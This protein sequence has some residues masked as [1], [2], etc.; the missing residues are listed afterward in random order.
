M[1]SFFEFT[2]NGIKFS[3]F[4]DIREELRNAWRATWGEAIDLSPTSPDGHHVDLEAKT[5]TFIT[6]ALQVVST[7]FNRKQAT[8]Q[9]LDYLAFLLHLSRGEGESDEALRLRMDEAETESLATSDGMITYLRDKIDRATDVL[10]N[11][12]DFTDDNGIP[13][14]SVRALIPESVSKS[15][16]EIAQ[17]IWHCKAAGVKTDGNINGVAIGKNGKEYGVKYSMIGKL[18]FDANIKLHLYSEEEFPSD[19]IELLKKQIIGWATGT[20]GWKKAEYQI[21]TDVIPTRFYTPIL[22][23][24][25]IADAEISVKKTS[26]SDF[27]SNIIP[28]GISEYAFINNLQ[29][30]IK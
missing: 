11:D 13:P 2:D 12:E 26:A 24:P 6:Q 27:S 8:G 1:A 30:E 10:F 4:Q 15:S 25:G 18:E 16:D 9:F 22:T 7:C 23:I 17:A 21:G 20:D 5:I 29:I 14:H 19:G 28:V 3:G